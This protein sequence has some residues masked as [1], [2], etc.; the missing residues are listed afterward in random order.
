MTKSSDYQHKKMEGKLFQ[1][2]G[3]AYAKALW[4]ERA[5]K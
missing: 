3:T 2:E 4:Q 5:Q 1:V